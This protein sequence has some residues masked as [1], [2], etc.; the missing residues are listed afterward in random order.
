MRKEVSYMRA[1]LASTVSPYGESPLHIILRIMLPVVIMSCSS[2]EDDGT[3]AAGETLCE[4][5]CVNLGTNPNHCGMCG[6][7]CGVNESCEEGICVCGEEYTECDSDCVDIDTDLMHCGRC[8]NRCDTQQLCL[9]G[10]CTTVSCEEAYP[11]MITCDGYCVDPLTDRRHCSGCHQ[12][13]GDGEQCVDGACMV[14]EDCVTYMDCLDDQICLYEKCAEAWGRTYRITIVQF[15]YFHD[16]SG[17]DPDGSCPD[18]RVCLYNGVDAFPGEVD[19]AEFC[20]SV[21]QDV[22]YGRWEDEY[23]DAVLLETDEW[24]VVSL[25]Q[26]SDGW[27]EIF[28]QYWGPFPIEGIQQGSL[29]GPDGDLITVELVE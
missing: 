3:C 19:S 23:F 10:Q 13:C 27:E 28:S 4:Q 12:A 21:L 11:G 14:V 18:L 1:K 24:L 5:Q 26:D 8:F 9:S 22:Q 17:W 29:V 25:D 6:K 15:M 2:C 20:T 16:C 7:E